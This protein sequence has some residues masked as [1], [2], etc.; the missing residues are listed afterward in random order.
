M[1]VRRELLRIEED[2]WRAAGDRDRY[3]T[4]LAA[5]AIHVFPGWGIAT[6]EA[7]LRGVAEADPWKTF[8]IRD[9]EV[10]V[11]SDETAALVYRARAQR[12]DE[13]PYT[14]AIT[15]VYRRR[16]GSWEL[17]IHQQTALSSD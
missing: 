10:L 12:R 2:L 1:D 11:L 13:P 5:D 4:S 8:S 9:P 7:V 14:A 16:S 6:R 3:G 15:S 17:V